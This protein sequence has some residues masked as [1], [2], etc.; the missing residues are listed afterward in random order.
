ML[1]SHTIDFTV[2]CS[3]KL[4]WDGVKIYVSR[5]LVVELDYEKEDVVI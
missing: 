2:L 3:H 4:L 1:V 5:T